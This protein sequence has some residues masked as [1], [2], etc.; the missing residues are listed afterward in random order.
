ME[1]RIE[2]ESGAYTVDTNDYD[3]REAGASEV[4]DIGNDIIAQEC[5]GICCWDCAL[6]QVDNR[7]ANAIADG[8]KYLEYLYYFQ[9]DECGHVSE[10][11][12]NA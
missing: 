4:C 6:K 9:F 5:A 8:K 10:E 7:E 3:G 12:D 1:I 11:D 2:N